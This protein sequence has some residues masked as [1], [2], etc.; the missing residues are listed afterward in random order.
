MHSPDVIQILFHYRLLLL[1]QLSTTWQ[2]S[3]IDSFRWGGS[4]YGREP[5][6]TGYQLSLRP[7]SPA[8]EII[9]PRPQHIFVVTLSARFGASSF[10][11]PLS[12]SL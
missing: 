4:S 2:D 5:C 6:Q 10:I 11:I 7:E 1:V 12:S 8:Y 3:S 9:D